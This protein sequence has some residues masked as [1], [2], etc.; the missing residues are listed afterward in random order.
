MPSPQ[1]L[2]NTLQPKKQ[3]VHTTIPIY[4]T[5]FI[6]GMQNTLLSMLKE[7][8]APIPHASE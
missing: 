2:Y 4:I 8:R 5:F 7:H 6:A 3:R 1:H